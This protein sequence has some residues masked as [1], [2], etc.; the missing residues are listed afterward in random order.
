MCLRLVPGQP[1][2]LSQSCSGAQRDKFLSRTAVHLPNHK[3]EALSFLLQ[4]LGQQNQQ[5]PCNSHTCSQGRTSGGIAT[6]VP[7][8]EPCTV[9]AC[10]QQ[11]FQCF[12]AQVS[13]P[14]FHRLFRGRVCALLDGKFCLDFSDGRFYYLYYLI[15]SKG[16][17]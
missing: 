4:K 3:P 9:T 5:M 2:N 15:F 1:V 11:L 8:W 16:Y 10:T 7:T 12:M 14:V 6:S 17:F 13:L